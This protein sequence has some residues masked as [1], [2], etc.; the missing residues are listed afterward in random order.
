MLLKLLYGFAPLWAGLAFI[1]LGGSG[2]NNA[3]YWN[4][5][6]WLVLPA[7]LAC[8][9]TMAVVAM[10]RKTLERAGVRL[11]AL[12]FVGANVLLVGGGAFLWHLNRTAKARDA[13]LETQA[14]AWLAVRPEVVEAIGK[15]RSIHLASTRA[16]SS[17]L[18]H[19]PFPDGFGMSLEGARHAYAWVEISGGDSKQPQFRLSCFT[20]PPET[21]TAGSGHCF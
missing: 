3:E 21:D 10:T 4:A 7:L 9:P 8:M 6:P 14:K 5:A 19:Y 13:R 15:P 1:I 18:W 20:V 11:A 17:S 12:V 16:R 2:T